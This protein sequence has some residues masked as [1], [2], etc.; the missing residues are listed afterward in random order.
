MPIDVTS[1]GRAQPTRQP[2]QL[3]ATEGCPRC[4]F[5]PLEDEATKLNDHVVVWNLATPL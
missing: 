2:H 5:K 4:Q 3:T 1:A